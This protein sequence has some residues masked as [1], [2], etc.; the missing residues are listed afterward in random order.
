VILS[1]T[2]IS[3]VPNSVITGDIGVSPIASTAITGFSLTMDQGNQFSRSGQLAGTSQAHAASYGG[4]IATTLTTAVGDME[5]AYTY[6][7]EGPGEINKTNI[8]RAYLGPVEGSSDHPLT[9]GVYTF[10]NDVTLDDNIYFNG[11]SNSVVIIRTSGNLQQLK[12]TQ[13]ILGDVDVNN[14]F[15]WQIAG[16]VVVE[17]GAQMAGI[18]LVKNDVLFMAESSLKGRVLAQTICDLQ[19]TTI[20]L[21]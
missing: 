15:C 1:K 8:A 4:D 10:T 6:A 7:A 3:T 20:D 9:A 19:K 14:V 16:S 17:E 12:N 5:A 11:D 21:A 18:V 13:V 2:G